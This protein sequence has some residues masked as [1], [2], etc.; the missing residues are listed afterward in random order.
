M[1]FLRSISP[2]ENRRAVTGL[3]VHLRVP[4][5][6]D[7]ADWVALRTASRT[8]LTPWEPLWPHD[9]LTRSSFRYRI[10]R[11][12][13]DVRDDVSYPFF[14]FSR[15]DDTLLGGITISNVRRGVA[16]TGSV[17]YWI[18]EP[19]ARQGYMTDAL[20]ALVAYAFGDLN[21]NRLEAACLPGNEPSIRLLQACGFCQEGLAREYLKI[22]GAWRD[23]LLFALLRRQAGLS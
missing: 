18:G 19:H 22:N 4:V 14:I 20:R 23:H 2:H 17:G 10:K 16:Q 12:H 21:L 13:R 9:D 15:D 6:A 11:Y 5:M 3:H 1:A 7:F 8:F